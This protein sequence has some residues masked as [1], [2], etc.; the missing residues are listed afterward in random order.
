[1]ADPRVTDPATTRGLVAACLAASLM[2]LNST[3]IAVA[4]PAISREMRHD[5][6]AV[7]QALVATYL[8]GAIALQSPGG[9]L[10][11]R[12]GQWR[13]FAFGQALLALGAVLGFLAPSLWL[14]TLS[15]VVI[16]AGGAI[17]VPATIALLRTELPEHQRGRAFGIFGS[18]MS[19]AAGIGPLIGGELV[20]LFG[21]PSIFL[22]NLPVLAV[23]AVLAATARH[24][25]TPLRPARFDWW[26]SFLL[27]A[28]LSSLVSGTEAHGDLSL[29]LVVA[30]LVLLI[31]F[32]LVE[33]RAPDP[34]VAFR[35]FRN[36]RFFAGT[37]VIA[38]LNLVMYAL[39]FEVPLVLSALFRL[40]AG[41]TGRVIVFMMLAMVV[42]S[43]VAGRITDRIGPRPLGIAG[44]LACLAGVVLLWVVPL[45]T[46]GD[47]RLALVLLGIGIGLAN[48]A[49]Q[50]A[51][52]HDVDRAESGMAAGMGSTMR[53][54]GGI[55]GV[56][57]LGRGLDATAGRETILAQHH[58]LLAIFAAVL[59]VTLACS[60]LLGRRP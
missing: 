13:A 46:P 16:A 60:A 40:D 59:V 56:A 26:G 35:L 39:L 51:S 42:T 52:M 37:L 1:M 57:T 43:S 9:K 41:Q 32:V 34:V 14:L 50:T 6:G 15:R 31:P 5:P 55:V 54:L 4:V 38:L 21:W 25:A 29:A 22:A 58:A 7:T 20:R 11:D 45:T 49:A 2:P 44:T 28:A 10:G 30:G 53:Y 36:T 12:I 17:V 48:P 33:R 24:L 19:L 3:M 23:S 8:V 18:V 27:A 47:V